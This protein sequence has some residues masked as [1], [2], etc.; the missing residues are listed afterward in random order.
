MFCCLVYFMALNN[1]VH[2]WRTN[3]EVSS[4]FVWNIF[5][6]TTFMYYEG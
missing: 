1:A 4:L 5:L 3:G 2:T 6:Q